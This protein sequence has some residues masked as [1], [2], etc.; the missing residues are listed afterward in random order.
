M[1]PSAEEIARVA[2]L[3]GKVLGKPAGAR[4]SVNG[5]DGI[6]GTFEG[7]AGQ[8]SSNYSLSPVSDKQGSPKRPRPEPAA[9]EEL[10]SANTEEEMPGIGDPAA[11][12]L[13][14]PN[15]PD[16]AA[17]S[18]PPADEGISL[19]K[20]D[21]AE[22][23]SILIEPRPSAPILAYEPVP[24]FTTPSN[25][26]PPVDIPQGTPPDTLPLA[27]TSSSSPAHAQDTPKSTKRKRNRP[28]KK[29]L[30]SVAHP[31]SAKDSYPFFTD[32]DLDGKLW[33]QDQDMYTYWVRRGL[34]A[35]WECGIEPED[36]VE[37]V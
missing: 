8:P 1:R 31:L 32:G 2:A 21:I 24:E 11:A 19:E 37:V 13:R 18:A 9:A 14:V 23:S 36:G 35:L 27:S 6:A 5:V 26:I 29:P 16:V 15:Q 10:A 20:T 28:R 30:F 34:L 12:A 7:S 3:I 33:F 17:A 22:P 4:P 25:D